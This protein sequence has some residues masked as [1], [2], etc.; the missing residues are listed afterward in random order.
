MKFP[1]KTWM[2]VIAGLL[3]LIVLLPRQTQAAETPPADSVYGLQ[4]TLRMAGSGEAVSLDVHRGRPVL[5]TM[6][7][8]SC[9]HVCPMLLSTI[10]Q[11]EARLAPQERKKLR[12]LAIS[13]DPERDTPATLAELA[14]AHGVDD[15]ANW[16][17]A[18]P[19][20][21]D[22]RPIAA[23]LGIRYRKLPDGN[24]NHTSTI[25]LL[26]E[27]GRPVARSSQLGSVDEAFLQTVRAQLTGSE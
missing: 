5:V 11:I 3:A 18:V 2:T 1:H 12:V 22:V 4:A 9:P 23:V 27:R 8:G 26:D 14:R 13:L 20:A 25:I 19:R 10:K 7:Y 17:L 21:P 15:H 6:F 16:L 24:F